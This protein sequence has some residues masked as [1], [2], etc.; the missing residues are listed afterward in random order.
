[1]FDL[2]GKVALVAGGAGYLGVPVCKGLAEQGAA[3]VIADIDIGRAEKAGAEISTAFSGARAKGIFLDVDNQQS[4][5]AAVKKAIAEFGRLDILVNATYHAIDKMVEELSGDEF[6]SSLHTNLTRTFV[7]AREAASAMKEAG[8]II[9][10]S[11]IYGEV[12]PDPRIY[13]L[14]M[15]P[16]PIDYGV[17]KAGIEQMVRYLS[18]YWGPRN[19]RVNAVAPG[20][21]PNPDAPGYAGNPEFVAFLERLARKVPLGRVGRRDEIVGA[22]VFLASDEASFVTGHVLVVDGG[23][24]VW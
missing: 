9:M 19:I 14:P 17:A 16:N 4:A 2:T 22:V 20:P 8:S 12:S 15:K 6:D 18:V 10:F 5:E 23:W 7:L 3:V 13:Q 11:S 21:F 1:M 24:T